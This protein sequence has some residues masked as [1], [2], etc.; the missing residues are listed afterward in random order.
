MTEA[1]ESHYEDE[2]GSD[3][4]ELAAAHGVATSYIGQDHDVH[5]TPVAALRGVLAA[6]DVDA[7]NADSVAA[8]L[9]EVRIRDW[10]R[11]LPPVVVVREGADRTVAVRAAATVEVELRCVLENGA[12]LGACVALP[13]RRPGPSV[14]GVPMSETHFALPTDLP[15]GWHELVVDVHGGITSTTLV[16]T[17]V[18]LPVPP[19]SWGLTTQ[20][21]SAR[22]RASWGLGDLGDLR[23]L[24]TWGADRGADFVAIN[25]IFAPAPTEPR[26][27]SPY[28]PIT[29]RFFDPLY[30]RVEEIPEYLEA[31]AEVR[32]GVDEI[33]RSARATGIAVELLDRDDAWKA[34]SRALWDLFSTRSRPDHIS[35]LDQF[36]A[37]EGDPLL[38]FAVWCS[39]VET[40]GHDVSRWPRA[41]ADADVEGIRE[42]ADRHPD[43]V[44]FQMWLQ[45]RLAEQTDAAQRAATAAGMSIGVIHD[46]PVGVDPGGVDVWTDRSL[47]ARGVTIGAP[48]DLFNQVGQNWS[49][50]PWRPDA[51]VDRA[52]RPLRDVLRSALVHGGGIRIDHVLGMFRLWWIPEGSSPEHGTYVHYDHEAMLGI[53]ALEAQRAGGVVIGEDMGTVQK[54]VA[55]SLRERELLGTSVLWFERRNGKPKRPEDWRTDVLACATIHDIP[56]T[57]GFLA[58]EHIRLR[59]SLGLLAESEDAAYEKHRKLVQTW[60]GIAR[61]RGFL[62]DGA[63]PRD[64]VVALNALVLHSPS[65]LRGVALVDL[66]GEWRAQNQPGTYREYPNWRIPLG[67]DHGETVLLDDVYADA[68]I[69]EFLTAIGAVPSQQ[70]RPTT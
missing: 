2:V 58:G 62:A 69:A 60:L 56:P 64:Q 41:L 19:R 68:S 25:P 45:W 47:F 3:L 4:A 37:S 53:V 65:L 49:L 63:S 20:L 23:E 8:A 40:Y 5:I 29:R 55:A 52:Y 14:D 44:R 39:S 66:V 36:I 27:P 51:L 16:V 43:I 35:G 61:E 57:A 48:P 67:N 50:P 59:N 15:L 54:S 46:L 22:S 9:A 33:A 30:L 31:P 12:D 11:P 26:E 18:R 42:F 32:G 38:S 13:S 28:M 6:L 10:R 34:K 70:V 17:P 21:Y 24:A 7:S 1:G